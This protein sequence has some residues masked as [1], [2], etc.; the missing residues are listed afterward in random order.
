MSLAEYRRKRDFGKTAEPRADA[1]TKRGKMPSFVV[2]LHHARRRHYDFRLEIGGVLKSWAIPKGPSFDPRVKRLAV[3]TE[4]HPLAYAKFEGDIPKGEYGGGHVQRFDHGTWSTSEASSTQLRKGHLRFTLHGRKL[5]GGWDLIRTSKVGAKQQWLLIKQNDEYAGPVEADDLVQDSKGGTERQVARMKTPRR[6]SRQRT[7]KE[8]LSTDADTLLALPGAKRSPALR[9]PWPPEL[10]TLVDA[11]PAD[12][13]WLHEVKW[14]GYRLLALRSGKS[15]SLWSRNAIEWSERLPE[16]VKALKQIDAAEFALD[17]ELVHLTGQHSDFNHLQAA[18]SEGN[19]AAL[20]YVVFDLVHCNGVDLR[21]VALRERKRV[22]RGLLDA[23]PS[24]LAYSTHHLGDGLRVFAEARKAGLEGI[25]SKLATSIYESGRGDTWRKCKVVQGDEFVVFGWTPP[26]GTRRHVGSLL[27]A[28][29]TRNGGWRYVGRVGS[30]FSEALLQR[31]GSLLPRLER[32]TPFTDVPRIAGARWIEPELVAEVD[33]RAITREGLLRQASLHGLREDKTMNDLLAEAKRK[34]SVKAAAAPARRRT[35]AASRKTS[36]PA[37]IKITHPDRVVYPAAG[38][39]KAEVAEYYAAVA[40]LL[41]QEAA[42]RPLSIVRC[43]G[44]VEKTC[45]FQK[46]EESSLG[47]AVHTVRLKE[48]SGKAARYFTIDSARGLAQLVQM[49]TIELHVWGARIDAPDLCD[50]LVFDL[51]PGADVAWKR[52]AS[53]AREVRESLQKMKLRS[54]LRVSG[55]KGLHVVVPLNPGAPWNQAHAFAEA[56]TRTLAAQS[57]ENYVAV[58]GEKNRKNRIFI[59]YLRNARGATSIANYSLR[60]REQATV[61]MPIDWTEL[62]RISSPAKFTLREVPALLK[63]RRRD[64]W[65]GID[66]VKQT[67]PAGSA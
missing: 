60:A 36:A 61:A 7:A 14:D 48:R 10:A 46:H 63:R 1:K 66:T 30:G 64:P 5:H 59:D 54:W 56:L 34:T 67:L 65:Q 11:P 29:P 52:V 23:V 20:T 13:G 28:A 49:N 16:I 37:P 51:D 62:S 35:E 39:T 38:I 15:V 22:L 42:R 27:L 40:P 18:L 33:Y 31:L 3:E 41:L 12:E 53:A 9:K 21:H 32:D 55:G 8:R 45:F 44:G 26:R 19:T 4:D 43:P 57:P 6:A 50:R 58:A 2:Q 24:P 17:G 25:V 47:D